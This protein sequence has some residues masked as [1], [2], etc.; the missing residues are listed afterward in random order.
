MSG[1]VDTSSRSCDHSECNRNAR[2]RAPKSPDRLDDFLWFCQKH[3]REY[4]SRWN[5]FNAKLADEDSSETKQRN[6]QQKAWLRHGVDDPFEILGSKSTRQQTAGR[7]VSHLTPDE[8]RAI[9]ILDVKPTWNKSQ[10]RQ[11]Y[12]TLVK[13]YHPDLNNGYREEEDRL[14]IVIW[15]WNQIKN[16]KHFAD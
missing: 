7:N 2:Y 12:T 11:Q 5:F 15:A 9:K 8:R 6:R 14:R 10:I 1:A 3:V 13:D 4:N 16:S